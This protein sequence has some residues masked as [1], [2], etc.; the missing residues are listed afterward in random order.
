LSGL[1]K[2]PLLF[3]FLFYPG[4]LFAQQADRPLKLDLGDAV[5]TG[6]SGLIA[7]KRL[8]RRPGNKLNTGRTLT[9]P[10]GAYAV[11][12]SKGRTGIDRCGRLCPDG[13]TV[14]GYSEEVGQVGGVG[15]PGREHGA[16]R[17][18]LLPAV[19]TVAI[20]EAERRRRARRWRCAAPRRKWPGCAPSRRHARRV[21]ISRSTC[22]LHRRR[23]RSSP[24]IARRPSSP[25]QTQASK[26]LRWVAVAR[27]C[28]PRSCRSGRRLH[29][30]LFRRHPIR[31]L[32]DAGGKVRCAT[33]A[34]SPL[35]L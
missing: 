27:D 10:E 3:W 7:P 19:G 26:S 29:R 4:V 6:F 25:G 11:M 12:M 1:I 22:R 16:R 34:S 8:Q 33:S 14:D 24:P 31:I 17:A 30:C 2:R 23:R 9:N 21:S 35:G 18:V 32:L 20:G 13:K 5:V 28:P 15:Q